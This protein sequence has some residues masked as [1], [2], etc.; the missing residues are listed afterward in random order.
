MRICLE[1]STFRARLAGIA[2]YTLFLADH[3]LA[4][5]PD[6]ELSGFDG[7]AFS[8]LDREALGN[9]RSG[10]R[11]GGGAGAARLYQ[12]VRQ[13]GPARAAF[14]AYK[15]LQFRR[16]SG[17]FDLFHAMNFMPPAETGTAVLPLVHDISHERFPEA[18]PAERTAWLRRRLASL[19]HY[20]LV[21]TVSDFSADEISDF[22]GYPRERIR[23]T[24]PGVNP[25]FRAPAPAATPAILDGLNLAPGGFFLSVGTMEPRK[26]HATL[27]AA[28]ACL[29]APTRRRFPLVQVG[30]PGWGRVEPAHLD[31]LVAEGSVRMVGYADE[32]TL[33]ALYASAR[34]LLF[35]TLYEGFGIPVA[36]AMA[37]GLPAIVSD[38][39]V[40]REVTGGMADF[41]AP[42]DVDGWA[43][44][45]LNAVEA[46]A[47]GLAGRRAA[48]RLASAAFT[49]EETARATAAIYRELA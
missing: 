34:A 22:Y 43:A 7:S 21:N 10:S 40:M 5:E 35:P 14:R 38:I 24:K 19:A 31:A 20:P 37:A 46:N 3:L 8:R 47:D 36:E 11:G 26:N 33:H 39:A 49:W 6:F 13:F 15:A 18:H 25:I 12:A 29:D 45:I 27:F 2:Y 44:A 42:L 16:G 48:A 30:Q 41:V 9:V 4:L 32:T 1:T 17:R 28:Y 23:V